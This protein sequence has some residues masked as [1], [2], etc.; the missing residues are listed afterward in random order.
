MD[1]GGEALKN[2]YFPEEPPHLYKINGLMIAEGGTEHY[3]SVIIARSKD[4]FGS[5]EGGT[6]MD[7][8]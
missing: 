5:Y 1:S 4:I 7:G 2:I 6:P 8:F 3:H